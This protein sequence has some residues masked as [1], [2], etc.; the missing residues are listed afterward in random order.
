MTDIPTREI[1]IFELKRNTGERG[2]R[3]WVAHKG[4]VYDVT[5]CSRWKK[6]LHENQHFPGQELTNELE[7]DAPHTESV[8]N[9]PCVQ[10]VGRL[11]P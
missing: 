1:S 10:L 2:T 11:K 3:M 6:G 4:I 9:N 7:E 5:D 8:F